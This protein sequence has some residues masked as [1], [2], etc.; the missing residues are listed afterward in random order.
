MSEETKEDFPV[1]LFLALAGSASATNGYA[2]LGLAG[3]QF[4][5]EKY[6]EAQTAEDKEKL[7]EELKK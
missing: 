7:L 4:F 5:I 3:Q 6:K 2:V 1:D